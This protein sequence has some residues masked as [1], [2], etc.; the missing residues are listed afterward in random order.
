MSGKMSL[1]IYIYVYIYIYINI[2]KG[3][4]QALSQTHTCT[5]VFGYICYSFP[6]ETVLSLSMAD[7]ARHFFIQHNLK[8][9]LDE[10]MRKHGDSATSWAWYD[11]L[12]HMNRIHDKEK[13]L[14][15]EKEQLIGFL[16]GVKEKGDGTVEEKA[17][18]ARRLKELKGEMSGL[19]KEKIDA[20]AHNVM[21]KARFRVRHSMN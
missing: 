20:I 19:L 12:P 7:L 9:N 1:Y 5:C 18:K 10:L 8:P 15:E 14:Q 2:A 17:C 6:L 11:I 13:A 16:E 4:R 21:S 3:I